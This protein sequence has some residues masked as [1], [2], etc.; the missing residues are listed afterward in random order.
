MHRGIPNSI[1]IL[2]RSH[3]TLSRPNHTHLW[4]LPTHL[5][6]DVCISPHQHLQQAVAISVALQLPELETGCLPRAPP[7]WRL[8]IGAALWLS[9]DPVKASQPLYMR[10]PLL[11]HWCQNILTSAFCSIFPS[12][13]QHS[14]LTTQIHYGCSTTPVY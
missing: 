5:S 14:I 7:H 4:V 8:P 10:P 3:V 1:E 13:L 9:S 6:A 11:L 2:F 12:S